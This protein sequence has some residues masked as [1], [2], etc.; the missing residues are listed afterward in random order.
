[1]NAIE[2]LQVN[3]DLTR[4]IHA[5][6]DH[7]IC[8]T[9]AAQV[10]EARD[11]AAFAY[12]TAK[13]A[14]RL[15]AAKGAH[16]DIIARV[17]RAQADALEIESLAKRRLA[18]EYDA[19]QDRGEV[20]RSGT[21]TDLVTKGNEVVPTAADIGLTRKDVF[22]ARQIRD[23]IEKD[24]GVVRRVLDEMLTS[25]DEPTKARLRRELAGPIAKVRSAV[26]AEKKD[27]R[28]HREI[29]LSARIR[30]LPSKKYGVI[31]ADPEWRFEPYSR[32]SGMDRAPD[33]H[34][35]TSATEEIMSRDV[36]SIAADDCVLFLWA[37][38]PMLP[39]ALKV[40]AA[41]GFEYKTHAI[42]VKERVGEARGT[43]YWFTGE[44]ELLLLG[45]RGAPP[46]PA[47][48]MQW[49]S[50]IHAPIG[51]H[52]EKPEDSLELIEDYFPSLPKIELNRRGPARDGWEAWGAE[53][54]EIE[55][56]P[57]AEASRPKVDPDGEVVH[58]D[59]DILLVLPHPRLKRNMA[60]IKVHQHTDS[61]WMW[62]TSFTA[63]DRG[64]GYQVGPK[65]GNFA[66]TQ[67]HAILSAALEMQGRVEGNKHADARKIAEW[68]AELKANAERALEV[69]A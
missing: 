7:L 60:E 37:T 25:G 59:V 2:P 17:Y 58:G 39:D 48:G 16:D 54:D 20:G 13:R 33:N 26:Q 38:A 47:M 51:E 8:A 14:A 57:V 62:S 53:A 18:D 6:A 19:A 22:E 4:L 56:E 40:M 27:R 68:V 41:W 34:Y 11:K 50:V 29:E 46:A 32:E 9:T 61:R 52:S 65:W 31:L 3:G 64:G 23:A 49:P 30:A 44:H 36:G 12:D 10:L 24:P 35:P 69:A 63:G 55:P 15:A 45:V 66:E 28:V 42:W 1:M 21:R 67:T 43:G 5:A